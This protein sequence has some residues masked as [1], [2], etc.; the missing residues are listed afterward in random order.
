MKETCIICG[1][2]AN[3]DPSLHHQRY[4][5]LPRVRRDGRTLEFSYLTYAFTHEVRR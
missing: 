2:V 4:R 1:M 5:H 3:I